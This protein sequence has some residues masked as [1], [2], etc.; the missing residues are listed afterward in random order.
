MHHI[1]ILYKNSISCCC[2][3]KDSTNV[4]A[5]HNDQFSKLCTLILQLQYHVTTV[6]KLAGK[7]VKKE[8]RRLNK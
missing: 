6:T 3:G 5:Q 4:I 7:P 1:P 8:P 2:W